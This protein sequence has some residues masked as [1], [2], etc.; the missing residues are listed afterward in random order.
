M[1]NTRETGPWIAAACALVLGLAGMAAGI[2]VQLPAAP[3]PEPAAQAQAAS[4]QTQTRTAAARAFSPQAAAVKTG[5]A[6]P[7]ALDVAKARTVALQTPRRDVKSSTARTVV[8]YT[9]APQ[10][11]E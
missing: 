3:A 5:A 9:S 11:H 10:R 7:G 8:S 6:K 2:I 4:V 1:Q